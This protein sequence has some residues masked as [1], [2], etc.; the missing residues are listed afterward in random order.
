MSAQVSAQVA[1]LMA[2]Y[3]AEKTIHQAVDSIL[4]STVPCDLFVVDDCSRIPVEQVVGSSAGVTFIRLTRN[5]GLAAALNVGLQRILPLGY[6]YI[7]RMDADDISYPDRFAAQIAFLE[8]HPGVGLVGGGARFI[9]E[10]TDAVVM[11]YVPPLAHQEIRN[12][13]YFNNCFVHPSWLLRGEVMAHLGPYSL[14]YPAAEDYEFLRRAASHVILANVPDFLL[15]YRVSSGGI[16]VSKRHRQLFD[17][18][19][20]QLR[21]LDAL[22]WRC[23]AG[24]AKTLLL[25][26]LPRKVVTI[27]KAEWRSRRER[28]HAV[29]RRAGLPR[30]RSEIAKPHP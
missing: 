15:D 3:N 13:L 16:S 9:D 4:A 18:L 7:A 17:R 28:D 23:W 30:D 2:A 21:Y 8:R 19:K 27:L 1:V 26:L 12:A 14:D 20:I 10:R 6:K 5:C 22:E 25:F 24:M 11:H 29:Y